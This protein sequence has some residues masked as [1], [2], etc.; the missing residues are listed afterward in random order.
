MLLLPFNP[1]GL[2]IEEANQMVVMIIKVSQ[3]IVPSKTSISLYFLQ[4]TEL[5]YILTVFYFGV[6][7]KVI[8]NK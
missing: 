8:N 2:S 4:N 6:R 5:D 7:N 3:L 1:F